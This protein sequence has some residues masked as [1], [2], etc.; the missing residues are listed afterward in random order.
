MSADSRL[1]LLLAFAL[2]GCGRREPVSGPYD[3]PVFRERVAIRQ[4][5]LREKLES[6][7]LPALR[8][9]QVD[10][11]IVLDR[12][13]QPD[14]LHDE[15]GGGYSGAGAAYVFADG[16]DGKVEKT[17]LGASEQPLGF[18]I[19]QLYEEKKFYRG[20][21][22]MARLLGEIVRQRNPRRIA[23]NR[24][25]AFGSAD[26]LTASFEA[27]LAEALGRP[28]AERLVS[29]EPV[30]HE[31][32][33]RRT[34]RESEWYKRLQGWTARWQT[35]ALGQVEPSR[36][37]VLDLVCRLEDRAAELGLAT[38]DDH[39][40]FPVIIWFGDRGGMP[41]LG[42]FEIARPLLP[43]R[44][45]WTD[46]R[47]FP[48]EPGDLI[49]VDGGLKL[50]GFATDMKRTAYVLKRGE[51]EPPAS[52]RAAWE[53]TLKVAAVFAS[54]LVPG[55][56]GHEI[57][58]DVAANLAASGFEVAGAGEAPPG[59]NRARV[60]LYG[61][62]VGNVV[63]DVGVRVT[64]LDPSESSA[65]GLP[66]VQGEWVSV[67]FHLETPA[68][69][70]AAAKWYTRFEQTAQVGPRGAEWLVPLQRELLLISPGQD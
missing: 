31:F 1:P 65:R 4:S 53:A 25:A 66:L 9:N 61:H 40:R 44:L 29:A 17:Y 63:H 37:T 43:G 2:A 12:E 35:E 6:S 59:S 48:I 55:A 32:R 70:G 13:N 64:A 15:L 39:G 67:E 46:A 5:I 24:S 52:L 49:A 27:F 62:S 68:A 30:V 8:N 57:W 58:R 38:A 10:M 45:P 11:W 14:P 3:I 22:E 33:A 60:V 51:T 34:P 50:L 47:D 16:G 28:Y 26:G 19:S 36:T 56:A 54:R 21:Q 42:G 69:D 20:Q 7:L 41:G 23:V 18:A